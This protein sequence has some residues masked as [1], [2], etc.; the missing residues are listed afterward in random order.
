MIRTIKKMFQKPSAMAL[1][2]QELEDSQRNFLAQMSAA[3][4]H[5]HLAVYYDEKIERL[6][7]Y[8]G[9]E[10]NVFNPEKK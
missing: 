10:S 5:T 9:V 3:E 7:N 4:Y 2:V 8:I 1:A 6:K